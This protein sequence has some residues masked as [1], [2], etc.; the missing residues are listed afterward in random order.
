[1]YNVN[2]YLIQSDS[3]HLALTKEKSAE[4]AECSKTQELIVQQQP[5]G[6]ESKSEKAKRMVSHYYLQVQC[7][8]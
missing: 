5:Q 6:Q 1:M 3:E 2:I 8:I 7:T 4:V